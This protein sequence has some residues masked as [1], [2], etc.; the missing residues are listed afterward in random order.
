MIRT[1]AYYFSLLLFLATF[2]NTA[3]SQKDT[4]KN[5][6]IDSLILKRK[7]IIKQIAQNLLVDTS[8]ENGKDYLRNDVPFQPYDNKIIRKIT[9]QSVGFG[10][11][12]NDTTR[13]FDNFLTRVSDKFH[14]RTRSFVISNNLFFKPYDKLSPYL[15]GNNERYLRDLPYFQEARI[16]PIPVGDNMDSVDILVLTK[17]VLSIGG[18]LDVRNMQ[19]AA[20]T[21][22]EDNF[23]GWGDRIQFQGLYDKLRH[24]PFGYGYGYLKRNI[25]GS[26]ID[27]E[28][29]Y[30]NFNNAFNS[31]RT[32]EEDAYIHFVKPLVNPYML[33]TYAFNAETHKSANMFISDSAYNNEW[34]YKYGVLDAWAGLNLSTKNIGSDNEF[35]RLRWL[36]SIRALHQKF[37]DKPLMY[38]DQYYY[39][40]ASSDAVLGA[41]SIFKLNFYKTQYIYGFGRNEDLPEGLEASVTGGW[42]NIEGRKRPYGAINIQHYYFLK[43]EAYV[44]YAFKLGSYFYKG[45][46]EDV[47]L[48]ANVDYYS[49]LHRL[50]RRWKQREFLNLSFGRQINSLLN[51]PLRLES[52]Y[53]LDYFHNN[54][55]AGN[56][57]IT[58]KAESVFFSPW[59]VLFFKIAPFIFG[60]ASVFYFNPPNQEQKLFS[61]VGGGIRTRNES[62]IFGT[63]ELRAAYFPQKDFYNNS[64]IIQFNTN[65]RFKYTQ[66]FIKRPEFVQMN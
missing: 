43:R 17:D 4:S 12:I 60:N 28:A 8:R 52:T 40:Y 31:G 59:S 2:T 33:W 55:R 50:T 1:V 3:N 22:K 53:G 16:I 34:K 18:S 41:V 49:R 15:L 35:R 44:N 38:K 64:Y 61:A 14:R 65:V 36:L 6:P 54:F 9:I 66:N 25:G 47:N 29:G 51:E 5:N 56:T 30:L 42:T 48:L 23:Y 27:G 39:S 24:N 46:A 13:H 45:K 11:S 21:I 10:V 62:L 32:E 19:S 20:V 58:A 63:I 7:G 37:S 57:R 26:F